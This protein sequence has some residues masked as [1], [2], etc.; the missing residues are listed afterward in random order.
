[1]NT[2]PTSVL[3]QF[4]GPVPDPAAAEPVLTA[5]K[6]VAPTFHEICLSDFHRVLAPL[7]SCATES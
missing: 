5:V 7:A 2:K 1:M 6:V 4:P 3:G